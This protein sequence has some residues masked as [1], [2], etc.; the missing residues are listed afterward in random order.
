MFF[1][2]TRTRHTRFALS[3]SDICAH[4]V[5]TAAKAELPGQ[6]VRRLADDPHPLLVDAEE[7]MRG[8]EGDQVR[9]IVAAAMRPILD[10]VQVHGGAAAA[11]NLT[12]VAVAHED[13]VA[14]CHPLLHVRFPDGNE[15]LC[16]LHQ[17]RS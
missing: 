14:P 3:A 5:P 8:A 2:G 11:G 6:I 12:A 16:E 9:L 13:P 1:V 17:T 7:M 10:V 15:V 4:P